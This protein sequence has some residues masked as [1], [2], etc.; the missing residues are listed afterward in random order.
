MRQRSRASGEP[1]KTRRRKAEMPKRG[2]APTIPQSDPDA[3]GNRDDVVHLVGERDEAL[4]R[5]LKYCAQS[6]ARQRMSQRRFGQSQKASPDC[7]M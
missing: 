7:L 4:E 3:V 1:V 2:N 6:P 5:H